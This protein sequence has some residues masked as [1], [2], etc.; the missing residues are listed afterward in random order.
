MWEVNREAARLL[1]RHGHIRQAIPHFEKAAALMDTDFNNPAML[2]TCYSAI[3]DTAMALDAAKRTLE[4]AER[5]IAQ[6]PTNCSALAIGASALN[7][8]GQLD[9]ARD[10]VNRALLLDPDNFLVRYNLACTLALE[11][12]DPEGAIEAITPFFER[13][14]STTMMRHLEADP[15]LDP[16]RKD[17]RFIA[18]LANARARLDAA[19]VG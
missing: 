11:L 12:N 16:I 9:R 18:M 17:P 3:G 7:A 6:D 13:V 5:T 8:V 15:D 4:R 19:K 2:I 10:W 14:T 1:F